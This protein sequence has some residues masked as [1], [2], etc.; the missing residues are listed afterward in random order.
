MSIA[1]ILF[2]STLVSG[3]LLGYYLLVLRNRKLHSFNRMYLICTVL[4]SLLVPFLHFDLYTISEASSATAVRLLE[5]LSGGGVEEAVPMQVASAFTIADAVYM[6]YALVSLILLVLTVGNIVWLYRIKA[7]SKVVRM[8]GYNLIAT[9]LSKAPFSFFNNLFWKE[10]IDPDSVAGKLVLQHE[11]THIQQRHTLDKL[12]MQAVIII[13]WINPIYWLIQKELSLVHEFLADEKA[14]KDNDTASFAMMLLESHYKSALPVIVNPFY[15]STKRRIM[16][17]N[18]TNKMRYTILRK[19]IA[20]PMLA[21]LVVLLSCTVRKETKVSRTAN[22]MLLILD[23]GHGGRDAGGTGAGGL[24]EKELALNICNKLSEIADEY[25]VEVIRTRTG[26]DY[27]TLAERTD[28]ANKEK[29]GV[30]VS[31]HIGKTI[32]GTPPVAGFELVVSG[33]NVM[34]KESTLLASAVSQQLESAGKKTRLV[35]RGLLV[36]KGNQHPAILIECGNIDIA[37]DMAAVTDKAQMEAM[38]R[39]ILSGVVA[40]QNATTKK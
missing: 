29:D 21:L 26:D 14:I 19:L 6:L 4:V 18:Q 17:I 37:A 30:F 35:D 24:I 11:L 1:T 9:N 34:L 38:C 40:Y 28:I 31:I 8:N 39:N 15:S 12:M 2:K 3:I 33:K 22:K 16:M 36:L 32:P 25:N 20:L 23:A 10:D 5:V 27:P 13:G 7:K